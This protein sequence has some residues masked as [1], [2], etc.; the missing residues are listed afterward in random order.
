MQRIGVNILEGKPAWLRILSQEGVPIDPNSDILIAD[1]KVPE[2]IELLR[3]GW[4]VLTTLKN[5]GKDIRERIRK[6]ES[7]PFGYYAGDVGNGY[8]LVL[9]FDPEQNPYKRKRKA[10]FSDYGLPPDESVA[11]TDTGKERRTVVRC[12][13]ELFARK[14]IPYVHKWYYPKGKSLFSLRIDT[15]FSTSKEVLTIQEYLQNMGI[16]ATI[17]LNALVLKERLDDILRS[18]HTYGVHCYYH[19][20]YPD[21]MRNYENIKK[22][23]QLLEKAGGELRGFAAPYGLWHREFPSVLEELGLSYSSEFGLSYDDLP[24]RPDIERNIFQ[25]PIHPICPERLF[26]SKHSQRD[27]I[28]Y[29]ISLINRNHKMGEPTIIYS[30]P[31]TLIKNFEM[32]KEILGYAVRKSDLWLTDMDEIDSWWRKREKYNLRC[33]FENNKLILDESMPLLLE[34]I[35]PNNKRCICD[36]DRHIYLSKMKFTTPSSIISLPEVNTSRLRLILREIE[37]R[38]NV[39]RNRRLERSK[40]A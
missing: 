27:V 16:K 3:K 34:I 24:F 17:F 12:L 36:A 21:R 26:T 15:D 22:A 23:K 8:I 4:F 39:R 32:L 9:G 25:I 20:V 28:D 11:T 14:G 13:R 7:G 33:S 10:F 38:L 31:T 29:Y 1:R 35:L 18:N 6:V 40:F 19:T 30:H 5:V 2:L 37:A